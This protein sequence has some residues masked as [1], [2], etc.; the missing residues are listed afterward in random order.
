[1]DEYNEALMQFKL[2]QRAESK[3]DAFAKYYFQLI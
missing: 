2:L 1:M 3:V